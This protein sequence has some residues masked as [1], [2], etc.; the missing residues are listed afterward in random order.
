[1]LKVDIDDVGDIFRASYAREVLCS[2]AAA[3]T[4]PRAG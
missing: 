3:L 2:P 1:M 4:I